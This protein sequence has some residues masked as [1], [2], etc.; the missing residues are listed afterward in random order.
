MDTVKEPEQQIRELILK[1][2]RKHKGRHNAISR[3]KLRSRVMRGM[4][5]GQSNVSDRE[6]RKQIE[7]L[8]N[9]DEEGALI[10]A[11]AG[12]K[13]YWIAVDL[14]DVLEGYRQERKRAITLLVTMRNRLKRAR[15]HFG[16]QER[17]L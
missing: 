15:E 3:T 11:S 9:H 8:R 4:P 1:T 7:W 12:V 16:G 5:R 6:I 13:G 10:C 17:L 2:L 14:E